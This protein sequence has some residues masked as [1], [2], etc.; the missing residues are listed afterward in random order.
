MTSAWFY[1]IALVG[2]LVLLALVALMA[3]DVLRLLRQLRSE[4]CNQQMTLILSTARS[5]VLKC[6]A[7]AFLAWP[8]YSIY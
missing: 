2:S 4:R 5:L 8:L 3:R 7:A 6:Y 1:G